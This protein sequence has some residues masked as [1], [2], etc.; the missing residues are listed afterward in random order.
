[1]LFLIGLWMNLFLPPSLLNCEAKERVFQRFHALNNKEKVEQFIVAH[2]KNPCEEIRPYVYTA[3]MMQAKYEAWPHQK[4]LH[5]NRGRKKLEHFIEENPQNLEAKY[6]RYLIQKQS[7]SFLNY[8]K[9]QKEDRAFVLLNLTKT[10]LSKAVKKIILK[11]ITSTKQ[12]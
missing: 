2:Q 10:P 9:N 5:F 12:G 3:I 8:I 6:L 7:P 1:M 4:M 11:N